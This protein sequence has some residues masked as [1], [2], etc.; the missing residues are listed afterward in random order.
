MS[1]VAMAVLHRPWAQGLRKGDEHPAYI[2]FGYG[3][4]YL[5]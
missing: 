4:L 3:T 5:Y 1:G 2:P